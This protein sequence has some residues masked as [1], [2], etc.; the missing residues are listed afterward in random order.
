ML[1]TSSYTK[2][3]KYF[4]NCCPKTFT[5]F[6]SCSNRL[7]TKVKVKLKAR[8]N[9]SKGFHF[10]DKVAVKNLANSSNKMSVMVLKTCLAVYLAKLEP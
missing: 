9:F 6:K 4:M 8:T 5:W 3:G 1:K 2:P 7:R 10:S